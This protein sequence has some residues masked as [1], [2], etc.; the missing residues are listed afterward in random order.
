M[1][2]YIIMT[3]SGCLIV[4]VACS[5][6]N[7]QRQNITESTVAPAPNGLTLP[8]NYKDWRVIAV[9]HRTD[10][11]SLRA[12]LGNDI[13]IKAARSGHTNPWPDGTMLAKLVFKD[14]VHEE[15]WPTATVPGKFIHAEFMVK[16]AQKYMQTG[17]WGFGRWLGDEQ[18]PYGNDAAFVEEC[19]ACHTP[20]QDNDYVFTHPVT[21]P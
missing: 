20:M 17:G 9:S 14:T 15:D 13:A 6:Q 1:S 2:K 21:L 11:E 5:P 18:K 19:F 3:L 16:D 4:A 7:T 12:I 8:A 10:N